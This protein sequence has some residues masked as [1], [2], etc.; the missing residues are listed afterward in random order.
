MSEST[1]IVQRATWRLQKMESDRALCFSTIYNKLAEAR[2]G[3][4]VTVL[5]KNRPLDSKYFPLILEHSNWCWDN[6][7]S[8]DIY[9]RAQ[10]FYA[11]DRYKGIHSILHDKSVRNLKLYLHRLES[12]QRQ[13]G[14]SKY[15]RTQAESIV[16]DIRRS[17]ELVLYFLHL[18]KT[19][20]QE[21]QLRYVITRAHALSPYYLLGYTIIREMAIEGKS[22]VVDVIQEVAPRLKEA[23]D[24]LNSDSRLMEVWKK[25]IE[26]THNVC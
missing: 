2:T 21:E 14:S 9:L 13:D 4:F 25:E 11:G 10:F 20:K 26:A 1:N 8:P 16:A 12:L 5:G 22:P 7:V 6:W 19:I 15:V 24:K 23:W 18:S 3:H 17:H